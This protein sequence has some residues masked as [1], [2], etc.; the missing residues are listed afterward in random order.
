M[1]YS[2]SFQDIKEQKKEEYRIPFYFSYDRW[3]V[4]DYR[5]PG[6]HAATYSLEGLIKLGTFNMLSTVVRSMI[7][8]MDFSNDSYFYKDIPVSHDIIKYLSGTKPLDLKFMITRLSDVES[9]RHAI[10]A[11]PIVQ[12]RIKEFISKLNHTLTNVEINNLIV[13]P[14]LLKNNYIKKDVLNKIS[15]SL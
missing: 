6:C 13:D 9:T 1:N 2:K 4:L 15:I 14:F 7:Q 3:T 10:S 11:N 5:I 8:Y 12:S